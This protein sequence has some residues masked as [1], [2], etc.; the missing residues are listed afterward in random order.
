MFYA[1]AASHLY[2]TAKEKNYLLIST[3]ISSSI[4]DFSSLLR[5]SYSFGNAAK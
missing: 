5:F 3:N 4:T 2:K 1:E